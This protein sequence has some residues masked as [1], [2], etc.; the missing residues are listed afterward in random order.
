MLLK[1]L[2]SLPLLSILA[3]TCSAAHAT[4]STDYGTNALRRWSAE[5]Q[6]FEA[7]HDYSKQTHEFTQQYQDK[8]KAE[9]PAQEKTEVKSRKQRLQ[10]NAQNKKALNKARKNKTK[11]IT[12]KN[13]TIEEQYEATQK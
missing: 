12:S 8:K 13:I 10:E 3:L 9:K 2:L 11:N 7:P 4:I 6:I 5:S 1:P